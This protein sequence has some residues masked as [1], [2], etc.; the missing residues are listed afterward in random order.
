[1]S[2][3]YEETK[4]L[5]KK[6]NISANKKLG[7]NFLVDEEI[8]NK[9]VE[10]ADVK[11]TDLI[12]EVG[13]G[14]GTLTKPL[15]EKAA[16]VIC[17]ELD[18]KMLSILKNRFGSYN[19]F[20]VINEDILKVDLKSIINKA[21]KEKDIKKAKI[22][23]N[24][25]YYITTPIIMKLLEEDLDIDSITVMIQKEV[26]DRLTAIPGN[27]NTGA[28]T[29]AVYY[30]ASAEQVCFVPNQSF[31]PKPEVNSEVIKLTLRS[32]PVI[33]TNKEI[34]FSII[35]SAFM[36]RRKTLVNALQ[37]N[38]ILKDK[39]KQEIENILEQAGIDKKARGETL[40]IED[41]SRIVEIIETIIKV[42]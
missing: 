25:P 12:I 31:I 9:I 32:E 14:L 6:Y 19:N 1:M 17:V 13:P 23:A 38:F 24:L 4:F 35:K 27:K 20:K 8:V 40:K 3:L 30:Y 33:D 37:N 34:L 42:V 5:M 36:Q 39:S 15:L 2:N 22:V 41:Y 11:D 16:K 7:Q 26:A 21:K 29:Y 18:Y 10:E 28:I